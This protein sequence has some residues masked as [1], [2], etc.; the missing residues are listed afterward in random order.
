ML[1]YVPVASYDQ[2]SHT[3]PH[4]YHLDYQNAMVPLTLP[5]AVHAAYDNDIGNTWPKRHA[6]PHFSHFD[7]RE[8]VVLLLMPSA[9]YDTNPSVDW[10]CCTS[11]QLFELRNKLRS[12]LIPFTPCDAKTGANGIICTRLVFHL[13]LII[14]T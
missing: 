10:P 9:W 11:F 1:M 12:F 5:S 8:W 4:F 14:V 7:I 13:I 2:E 6:A 3:T